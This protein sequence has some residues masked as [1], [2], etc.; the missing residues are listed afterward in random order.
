VYH[1]PTSWEFI[2]Y[3]NVLQD[4]EII[5]T[6]VTEHTLTGSKEISRKVEVIYG[7]VRVG[8]THINEYL[9]SDCGS[10]QFYNF[11]PMN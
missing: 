6:I 1:F 5:T 8:E 3:G 2:D 10:T 11:A 4:Y 9:F 7:P